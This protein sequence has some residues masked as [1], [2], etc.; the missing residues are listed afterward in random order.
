M[1]YDGALD[2]A[3]GGSAKAKKWTNKTLLWSELVSKILEKNVTNETY[4]EYMAADKQVQSSIKD[5]GGFVGGYLR[6]GRRKPE[7][8][9]YRQLVTLDIDFAHLDFWDDFCMMYDNAAVIHATH[10]HCEAEPRYRLILP[11][12]REVTPD[13]YG[14]IARRIAGNM[15]IELFDDTGFQPYRLM[16][17]P[18]TSKDVK[19]YCEKQDGPW[20]DPDEI[21]KSYQ[22]WRDS[23][24]WPTAAAYT[25]QMASNL[26]KQKDPE[27]KKGIV[28]TFCRCFTISEVIEEFLSDEYTPTT[29]GRYTYAKGT[30]SSGMVVYD[31]KFAY[32]HHST[33]PSGEQLCNSFDLV[34]LHKFGH[35]DADSE[36]KG[37]KTQ[38]Y[39]DMVEFARA[40]KQVRKLIAEENLVDA[41]Y[42]FAEDVD[43]EEDVDVD[44][45]TG[46][47]VDG[48]GKY[49]SDANNINLILAND[50]MLRGTFMQNEFDSKRYVMSNTPWR[51]VSTPEAIKNVDFSGLRNYI[52]SLY[53]IVG[54]LKID[55]AA[56]ITFEKDSFHPV[57]EYLT[58][59]EWDG[60]KRVD[61][62]LIDY[63]G[64]DDNIYSKEAIRKMLVGAVG[65][66]FRPGIKFD[67]VLTLVGSQ[68]TGKST[69]IKKLGGDWF[70]DT[71]MTVQG[72]EALEQIQGAWLIEM[73]ELS[74]L[75]KAEVEAVKHFITKQEDTFRPAFGRTS[76][77]Y[78]RQCVFF[79]TTNNRD[80]LRDPSGNRRFIPVDV[81]KSKVKKDVFNGLQP[82]EVAQIWAEA[83]E[84]YNTGEPLFMSAAADKLAKIEQ[85]EHSEVD[86]RAGII[87]EYLDTLLPKSWE[88][89]D[90]DDRRH[91]LSDPLGAV[92]TE[93]RRSVCIAEIWAECLG[94]S[95]QKMDKY[96]SREIND[97][98]RASTEWE[99]SKSIKT[100]KIYGRQRY[101]TRK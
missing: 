80:F 90:I 55:D 13:E 79:G 94:N 21:L 76:E 52:E 7:N 101:F 70:S 33:D 36:T 22:D 10:K 88:G 2:I 58:A 8:I 9:V 34:R 92:G 18:S 85:R 24:L 83:V 15:N 66:I 54:S 20:L 71:F 100:F 61:N 41:K 95:V 53:G 86:D 31:D 51:K 27:T 48:K 6:G 25:K 64:A 98:L 57:R 69:F 89:K 37:A 16:Y 74:G 28:G 77:T 17:W 91:F 67:L 29:E 14:A 39:K 1:E 84:L 65:R 72:K 11:L 96:K 97:I 87:E 50:T 78:K 93:E 44:W 81:N 56:A 38:S 42:D 26:S 99:Q 23:S 46:L 82:P 59:L 49:L 75:R 43:S 4:K 32:S 62:L 63:F 12:S 3:T 73:A 60:E 47:D 45:M 5:V 30:T 68:G 19:Y 35:L 40:D